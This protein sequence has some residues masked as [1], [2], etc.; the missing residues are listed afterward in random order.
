[1]SNISKKGLFIGRFQPLHLGHFS[2][3][4][5]AFDIVDFLYIGI[6]SAQYSNLPKNPFSFEERKE[7]LILAMKSNNISDDTYEIIPIPDIHD[8]EKWPAYVHSLVP[9]FDVV[10]VGK[11]EIVKELFEKY[12]SVTVMQVDWKIRINATEVRDLMANDGEWEARLN[13]STVKY[14]KEIGGVERIK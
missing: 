13:Q 1:M 7:M 10:F 5:Q 4:K 2:A 14:L 6:G 8:N 11:D 12:D 9:N 3:I